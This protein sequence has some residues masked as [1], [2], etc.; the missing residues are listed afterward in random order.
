MTLKIID[1]LGWE[2]TLII[3]GKRILRF[4]ANSDSTEQK[5]GLKKYGL[6]GELAWKQTFPENWII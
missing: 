2:T 3:K 6:S 1:Y 5:S 4:R